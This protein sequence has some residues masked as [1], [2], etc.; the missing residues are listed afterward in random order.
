VFDLSFRP[1]FLVFF[2]TIVQFNSY[3]EFVML[4]LNP[5]SF[6]ATPYFRTNYAL[7]II[8]LIFL[9]FTTITNAVEIF[10]YTQCSIAANATYNAAPNDTFLRDQNGNPTSNFSEA[11]GISYYSCKV[12]CAG[13]SKF[14]DWNV[15]SLQFGS[16]LLPW[17]ALTA[18]LPFETKSKSTNL[19]SLFLAIGSPILI[20]YSL[21]LTILN[22]RSINREFRQLKEEN[23]ELERPRQT[24]VIGAG[25]VILIESQSI[26]LQIINGADRELAQLIVNPENWTWWIAVKNEILKTKR[27]WTYSLIAQLIMVVTAQVLS[28]IDFFTSPADETTVSVGLGINS[29]WIWMIPVTFGWVKV[30]TQTSAGSIK[31]ALKSVPVPRLGGDTNVTGRCIGIRDRTQY[32]T[33]YQSWTAP[34][35]SFGTSGLHRRRHTEDDSSSTAMSNLE[36]LESQQVAFLNQTSGADIREYPTPPLSNTDQH[37]QTGPVS[38]NARGDISG[39]SDRNTNREIETPELHLD[40]QPE[41]TVRETFIGFSV[42]GDDSEP[43]PIF[44]YARVWSRMNAVARIVE[45]L[46]SFTDKQKR[47]PRQRVDREGPWDDSSWDVNLEGTP[48]QMSRYISARGLDVQFLPVHS[49]PLSGVAMNCFKASIAAIFLGWGTTGAGL[50]IAYK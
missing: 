49:Q 6:P 5:S 20:I 47:R 45:A 40:D 30:G 43:G 32:G 2:A 28:I 16:W 22:A 41:R 36:H 15:F 14:I 12:L 44:N 48:E 37:S 18:Q 9:N 39:D 21:A 7:L 19:Q 33:S 17:L 11:W 46:S 4:C 42:T 24:K 13:G 3:T 27:E 50:L 1:T 34:P 8:V 25:R 26:P 38:E 10:N 23:E 31:A 29:L 35:V